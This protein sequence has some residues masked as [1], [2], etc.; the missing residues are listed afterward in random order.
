MHHTED[1]SDQRRSARD[2][3]IDAAQR[4]VRIDRSFGGRAWEISN[5]T[6]TDNDLS[7]LRDDPD[8]RWIVGHK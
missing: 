2:N 3:A 8:F 7:I 6:S 4:A 1:G 5:P